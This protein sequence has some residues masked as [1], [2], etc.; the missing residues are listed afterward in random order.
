MTLTTDNQSLRR[1]VVPIRV[2]IDPMEKLLVANFK[3]D[4]EFEGLEPQVF[5]DPINGKGMRVLR[6]RKD[7]KVD[8]YWQPGVRVDRNTFSVGSG[9][10]DFMETSIEPALFKIT[11]RNVDLHVAFIDA[12]KRK[13]ELCVREDIQGKRG[14]PMLAPV[15]AD[16]EKP[17][18]LMLV[19][20]PSID[21]IRRS[22]SLV[23]GRVGDRIL[24]PASLP[25]LMGWQR[26][27]FVRYVP[28]PIIGTLN[29]L[30]IRPVLIELP[31]PGSA[32][33]EGMTVVVDGDGSVTRISAG[34]DPRLIEMDFSPGFPNML[35]LPKGGSATGRW[36]IRIANIPITGGSY[37]V[38][39][40]DERVAVELDVTEHW[41][42]SGLPLSMEIFTRVV[43]SFRTWPAT[44]R[45]R[46]FVELGSTPTMSGAWE[47]K[48]GK[49]K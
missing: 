32:D 11:E 26:V 22:G 38:S 34:E 21:L 43:R 1:V 23:E 6:Y 25:I 8:V 4:P 19:Y 44:Y 41:K 13:V 12:Q 37:T 30:M 9:I 10:G 42:P 46:G 20:M 2:G 40:E 27:W 45:W 5:D 15:G 49:I 35:D 16:V 39:H 29:P 31:A 24:S 36:S 48:G 18:R 7:R 33:V 28:M 47:R 14:F 3:S 17:P